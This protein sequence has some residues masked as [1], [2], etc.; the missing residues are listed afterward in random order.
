MSDLSPF[1]VVLSV[2]EKVE[3]RSD[4]PTE[5]SS[6]TSSRK[7]GLCRPKSEGKFRKTGGKDK[8]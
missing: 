6:P 2:E 1:F 3:E 4:E 7:A 5:G 8:S